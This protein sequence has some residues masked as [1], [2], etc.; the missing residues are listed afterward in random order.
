MSD[1]QNDLRRID[2]RPYGAYKDL[3][4]RAYQVGVYTLRFDHV[5]GDP[6]A[7]PSRLCVQVPSTVPQLRAHAVTSPDAQRATAD[8]LH[9]A[10]LVALRQGSRA[11]GGRMGSG[12]SGRIDI[13]AVGQEVLDRTA[14]LCV[15]RLMAQ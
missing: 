5:Q 13:A 1:I 3:S 15:W 4:G 12:K 7:S 11:A 10:L 14:V 6:F 8:F 2:R 9:R